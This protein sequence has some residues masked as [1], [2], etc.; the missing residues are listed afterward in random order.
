MLQS[1]GWDLAKAVRYVT[2]QT[3][4]QWEEVSRQDGLIRL[5]QA[6]ELGCLGHAHAAVIDGGIIGSL[7]D[8]QEASNILALHVHMSA[9]AGQR[10]LYS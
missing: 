2:R 6:Q 1:A 3:G 7:K 10:K 9:S 8:A 5:L 4:A